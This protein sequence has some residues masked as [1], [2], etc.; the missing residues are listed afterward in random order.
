VPDFKQA[1][2]AILKMDTFFSF[3]GVSKING[4]LM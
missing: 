3:H 2:F 1:V 4:R